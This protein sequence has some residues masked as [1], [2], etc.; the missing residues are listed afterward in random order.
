MSNAIICIASVS[1]TKL[2]PGCT[3]T[4]SYSVYVAVYILHIA[5]VVVYIPRCD[6]M[7]LYM[8]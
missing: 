8:Y 2:K 7:H 4:S 1:Y 5:A 6:S 3:F